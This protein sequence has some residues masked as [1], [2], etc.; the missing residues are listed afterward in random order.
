MVK[1]RGVNWPVNCA[2]Y[3]ADRRKGGGFFD[4]CMYIEGEGERERGRELEPYG[5]C[6][7]QDYRVSTD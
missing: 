7:L 5:L 6:L 4:T 2:I 1:E 3:E